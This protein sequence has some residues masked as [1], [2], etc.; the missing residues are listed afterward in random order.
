MITIARSLKRK[1]AL[2]AL[3][4]I[5]AGLTLWQ[6]NAMANSAQVKLAQPQTKSPHKPI[7]V[8]VSGNET[9]S[10]IAKIISPESLDT[11]AQPLSN[12]YFYID[13]GHNA[14]G[15]PPSNDGTCADRGTGPWPTPSGL[16][17]G[18][19]T[20][21]IADRLRSL[22]RANGVPQ[23]HIF[24][25][26]PTANWYVDLHNRVIGRDTNYQDPCNTY[27]NNLAYAVK[28]RPKDFW[29]FISIHL[30]A[31][32]GGTERVEVFRKVRFPGLPTI[33]LADDFAENM[34][35]ELN[36]P[37]PHPNAPY[38]GNWTR[39]YEPGQCNGEP[40][41]CDIYVVRYSH[42]WVDDFN[43]GPNPLHPPSFNILAEV[44][45]LDNNNFNQWIAQD[46]NKQAMAQAFYRGLTDFFV[47]G[48]QGSIRNKD[49]DIFE[50]YRQN[51]LQSRD[52][53]IPFDNGGGYYVHQYAS[54]PALT[55][56]FSSTTNL[57]G[58][59]LKPLS[60]GTS[61]PGPVPAHYVREPLWSTYLQKNGPYSNGPGLPLGEIHTWPAA[62]RT[63][64]V[65]QTY[66]YTNVVN[67]ERGAIIW[68]S[69]E[70]GMSPSYDQHGNFIANCNASGI[71]DPTFGYYLQGMVGRF[72]LGTDSTTRLGDPNS[73]DPNLRYPGNYRD[74][75]LHVH[76]SA[77]RGEVAQSLMWT[78]A[79]DNYT[80]P[81]W[82][83]DDIQNHWARPWIR[84]AAQHYI[85][86][87]Y[88]PQEWRPN[89][90]VT[91]QQFAKMEVLARGW[92][93]MDPV[94]PFI[95]NTCPDGY[96][97]FSDVCVGSVFYQYVETVKSHDA[98]SG[99][100]DSAHCTDDYPSPCFWPADPVTRGQMSKI[101]D[102][103]L[104]NDGYPQQACWYSDL[105]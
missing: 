35:W 22:L 10:D 1:Q 20:W 76:D 46:S 40:V 26:R 50:D 99:Y 3:A 101:I 82:E 64:S 67:F 45:Y 78:E 53:G 87:G 80:G 96:N 17:E 98:I 70:G 19:V 95:S 69:Y 89:E 105:P 7:E 29:R 68:N 6:N 94:A 66:F 57:K 83:Y 77:T 5:L 56:E 59:I 47:V 42:P 38:S 12:F 34:S 14:A 9:A 55:Q 88:N 92:S 21:D 97:S 13:P 18:D 104:I 58:S 91:R 93:L 54:A 100:N 37:Y 72:A 28:G 49:P 81:N 90:N 52:P 75:G 30:N 39:A 24:M 23:D 15:G 71:N 48:K 65:C 60:S 51:I 43:S 25:S 27:G 85:A 44:G 41:P 33:P 2:I 84:I 32:G 73:T 61:T 36:R 102:L 79:F 8:Q 63:C 11:G 4:L 31:G 86:N 62:R 16:V 103:A 74:A